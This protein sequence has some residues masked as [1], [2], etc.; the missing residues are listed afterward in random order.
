M[1]WFDNLI[2]WFSPKTACEREAW[3][4]QLQQLRGAGYD[5][6]D[7]GRLNA[8]WQAY[9]ESADLTDRVA[10]DTI[11]ARARDLERN[12]DLANEIILAFRRNVVGK[13]FTL[14]ARTQSDELNLSL[15]HISEPTRP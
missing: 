3:R 15:I 12:S 1:G 11:R 2:G 5:A 9:N 10:R 13:G 7:H 8:N 14:Q 6:A 4:L